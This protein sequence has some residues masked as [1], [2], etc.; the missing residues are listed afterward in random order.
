MTQLGIDNSNLMDRIVCMQRMK[1]CLMCKTGYRAGDISVRYK[2]G[3]RYRSGKAILVPQPVLPIA[4]SERKPNRNEDDYAGYSDHND[5][6]DSDHKTSQANVISILC[7][8]CRPRHSQFRYW[9]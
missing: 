5:N 2:K 3:D 9:A 4:T 1:L 6:S 7:A 8:T